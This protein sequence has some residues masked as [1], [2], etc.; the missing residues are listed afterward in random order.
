MEHWKNLSLEILSEVYEGELIIEEWRP[1]NGHDGRYEISSFGRIKGYGR[2]NKKDR[3]RVLK[4]NLKKNG[5]LYIEIHKNL[6]QSTKRV[7]RLV[8]LTFMEN[9]ENKPYVNHKDSCRSN[10]RLKNLEWSTAKENSE[11][12]KKKGRLKGSR[13][14]LGKIG[15]LNIKSKKV[16]QYDMSNRLIKVFYGTLE[17]GRETKIQPVNIGKVCRNERITAGGYK[18]KYI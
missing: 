10:N 13:S 7:H 8:L 1:L 6:I 15:K 12:A 14:M 17:A 2:Q 5:Y 9:P 18:W 16:G 3:I 4:Q 11:H